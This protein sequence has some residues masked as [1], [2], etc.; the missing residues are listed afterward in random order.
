M[1]L[2]RGRGPVTALNGYAAQVAA[3]TGGRGRLTLE[4]DG[5]DLCPDPEAV[6]AETDY[7]PER[8]TETMYY[9]SV[10]QKTKKEL[11]YMKE[12]PKILSE[13]ELLKVLKTQ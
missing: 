1:A 3:Y 12:N 13:V 9:F 8:D 11:D 7:D 2:L 6:L 5:Y 10:E 4:Q